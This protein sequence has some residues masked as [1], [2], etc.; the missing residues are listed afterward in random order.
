LV[1]CNDGITTT[2]KRPVHHPFFPL[3]LHRCGRLKTN[4]AKHQ[5]VEFTPFQC[6]F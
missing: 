2:Q 1:G 4:Q 3:N 6:Q 5:E